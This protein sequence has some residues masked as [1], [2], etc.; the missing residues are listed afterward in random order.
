MCR[1]GPPYEWNVVCA[2]DGLTV[3]GASHAVCR[4]KGY[5]GANDFHTVE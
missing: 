1:T 3:E 2:D 5:V 4:Q